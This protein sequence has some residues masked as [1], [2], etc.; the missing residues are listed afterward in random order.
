[1]SL[2]LYTGSGL[3]GFTLSLGVRH[4][5]V[6]EKAVKRVMVHLVVSRMGYWVQRFNLIQFKFC[7]EY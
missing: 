6:Q 4:S 7:V 2:S 5:G 3:Q 1:M